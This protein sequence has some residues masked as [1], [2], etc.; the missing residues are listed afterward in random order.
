MNKG[1]ANLFSSDEE[2]GGALDPRFIDETYYKVFAEKAKY[3]EEMDYVQNAMRDEIL[4]EA[5][6]IIEDTVA[7]MVMTAIEDTRENLTKTLEGTITETTE[8]VTKMM[9]AETA[10]V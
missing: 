7:D 2:D 8:K 5:E 9:K 4:E 6:Q 1:K 3:E 10:T